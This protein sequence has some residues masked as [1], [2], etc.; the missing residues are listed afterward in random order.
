MIY[1]EDDKQFIKNKLIESIFDQYKK[2]KRGIH[3]RPK[4]NVIQV[5]PTGPSH[6]SLISFSSK[7]MGRERYAVGNNIINRQLCFKHLF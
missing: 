2:P 5:I 4:H 1:N 3:L 7:D 6:S